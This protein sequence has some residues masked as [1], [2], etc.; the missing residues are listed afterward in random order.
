MWAV[1]VVLREGSFQGTCK[2]CV[3]DCCL[4]C[5]REGRRPGTVFEPHRYTAGMGWGALG[6]TSCLVYIQRGMLVS[7]WTFKPRAGKGIPQAPTSC[8]CVKGRLDFERR[9]EVNTQCVP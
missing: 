9:E 7:G 3:H 6:A 2:Q 5:L 4:S 8:D 1:T